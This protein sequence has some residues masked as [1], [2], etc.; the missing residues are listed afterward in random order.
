MYMEKDWLFKE[1]YNG[2]KTEGFL[3]DCARLEAGEPLAYIIGH[4][5]F[6]D[7]TI[8]LD[9]H[10]LIPCPETEYWTK[11]A[12]DTLI[13]PKVRDSIP[14][15]RVLDLCAGSGCIGVAIAR[16][17]PGTL[18][19]FC[20]ID[21]LHLPTILHNCTGNDI[22]PERCQIWQSDLFTNVPDGQY[23]MI[24]SNPPYIDPSLDRTTS[25]VTDYEP[26]QALYGGETGLVFLEQIIV[27]AP[28]YLKP[29]GQLWLEHEPEQ[30]KQIAAL[31]VAHGFSSTTHRDQYN[32]ERYTTLVLE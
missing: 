7:C 16:A 26:H 8:Y 24:V 6:L 14:Y 20:E 11:H 12:I 25:S 2:Q 29:Q 21:P 9:S 15:F 19:D 18:V 3:A 10:P 28:T 27:N 23:D 17:L 31:A 5:P 32:T 4:V 1:K 13:N 30:V 22:D